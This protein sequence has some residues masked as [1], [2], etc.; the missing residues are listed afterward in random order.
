MVEATGRRG[1]LEWQYLPTKFHENSSIGSK[2]I[3]GGHRQTH[4]HADRQTGDLLSPFPFFE[5]RLKIS[6]C[7]RKRSLLIQRFIRN[8]TATTVQNAV[9]NVKS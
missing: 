2:V 4:T 8:Q 6:G 9:L 1:H 3:S 7:L 5:S